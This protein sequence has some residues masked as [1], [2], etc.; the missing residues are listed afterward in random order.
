[1]TLSHFLCIYLQTRSTF[2]NDFIVCLCVCG[3]CVLIS[4]FLCLL[5]PVCTFPV[6]VHVF[7]SFTSHFPVVFRVA[8]LRSRH[9]TLSC[10]T[11]SHSHLCVPRHPLARFIALLSPRRGLR[12]RAGASSGPSRRRISRRA[13]A[14]CQAAA[15]AR[16]GCRARRLAEICSADTAAAAGRDA[17]RLPRTGPDPAG[18]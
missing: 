6:A 4:D 2:I 8:H 14:S 7:A 12:G 16:C 10:S 3:P 15:I 1:M 9:Q 17:E 5:C 13:A 18:H 11:L